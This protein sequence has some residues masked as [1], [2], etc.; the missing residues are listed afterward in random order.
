MAIKVTLFSDIDTYLKRGN[1]IVIATAISIPTNAP[2]ELGD[3][4]HLVEVNVLRALKGLQQPGKQIVATIYPMTTGRIYLLY[5]IGG[6]AGGTDFLAVPEL[7]VVEVPPNFDLK[8]LDGR[9]LRE[10]IALLFSQ[11]LAQVRRSLSEMEH[12]KQLLEKATSK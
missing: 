11:R 8:Q 10:Q 3:G 6:S 5:S 1:D 2:A 4:L 12:E 7:S 9:P